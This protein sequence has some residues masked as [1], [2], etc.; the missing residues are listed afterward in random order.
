M[1][2]IV[3]TEWAAECDPQDI[4]EIQSLSSKIKSEKHWDFLFVFLL[5]AH[6]KSHIVRFTWAVTKPPVNI[7]QHG[8]QMDKLSPEHPPVP[9]QLTAAL[10]LKSFNCVGGV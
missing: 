1:P 6:G 7:T 8:S 2:F 5:L 3:Y 4:G 9:G 10:T